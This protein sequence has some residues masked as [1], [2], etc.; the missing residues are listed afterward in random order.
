MPY[1]GT[2]TTFSLPANRAAACAGLSDRTVPLAEL[3]APAAP[4]GL[5]KAPKRTLVIGRF[6]ALHIKM[7]RI[8][9]EA[10]SRVPAM[11]KILLSRANPVAAPASPA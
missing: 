11:T 2:T 5:P 7:D 3:V 1:P 9:P 8:S 4:A 10:P 6:I